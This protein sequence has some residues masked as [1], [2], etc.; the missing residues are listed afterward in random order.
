MIKI[1]KTSY[2]GAQIGGGGELRQGDF[3]QFKVS[4]RQQSKD[5]AG[6]LSKNNQCQQTS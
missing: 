1:T 4:P 2:S 6:F 5:Q 3:S